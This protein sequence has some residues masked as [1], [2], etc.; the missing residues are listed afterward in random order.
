MT[1]HV[2]LTPISTKKKFELLYCCVA[3]LL[4]DEILPIRNLFLPPSVFLTFFEH[5]GDKLW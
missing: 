1:S 5:F 4:D 2:G 3:G